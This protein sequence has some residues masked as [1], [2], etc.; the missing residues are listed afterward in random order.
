MGR[1]LIHTLSF[2][3]LFLFFFFLL[4]LPLSGREGCLT[5]CVS[6]TQNCSDVG[7]RCVLVCD[8]LSVSSYNCYRVRRMAWRLTDCKVGVE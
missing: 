3:F 2:F 1:L 5:T 7:A 8:V 4:V 6:L